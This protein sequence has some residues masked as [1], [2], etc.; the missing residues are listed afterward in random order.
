M[1]TIL[2]LLIALNTTGA[3]SQL[4]DRAE[5]QKFWDDNIQA[6]VDFDQAKI[7]AQTHYPL[8]FGTS[9]G[10]RTKLTQTQFKAELSR[11]FSEAL[12][13]EL[14]KKT[15]DAI[16]AW[17]MYGDETETYMIALDS[18]P[19]GYDYVML[20]FLQFDGK[21]LLNSVGLEVE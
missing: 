20:T 16:D 18:A 13:T 4:S 1:K 8:E 7:L 14:S 19:E 15:I 2:L 3:F 11:V 9:T 6:I 5:A 10:A 17:K 12:R 21:W